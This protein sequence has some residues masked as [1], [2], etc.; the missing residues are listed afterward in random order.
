M[1][2]REDIFNALTPVFQN[3]FSDPSLILSETLNA[4]NV[5]NWD[6]LNHISL[7][8]E[9]ESLMQLT[10]STDEL[11]ELT[12]VGDFVNLIEKKGYMGS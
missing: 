9:I 11:I 1:K 5:E 2:T 4:S 7:I 6:S 12:N 8:V 3:V 10:F